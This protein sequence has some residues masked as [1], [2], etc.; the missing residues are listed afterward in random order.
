MSRFA[1]NSVQVGRKSSMRSY[2]QDCLQRQGAQDAR[3]GD[4]PPFPGLFAT[5]D[6]LEPELL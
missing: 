2:V 3:R 4:F 6:G 1:Q 5:R